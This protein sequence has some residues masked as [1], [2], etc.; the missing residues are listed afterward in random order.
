MRE[1]QHLHR[2]R[3]TITMQPQQQTVV[4]SAGP[5]V[6]PVYV[7]SQPYQTASVINSYLHRQSTVIGVLLIVGG[8]LSIDFNLVDVAV[9]ESWIRHDD[10]DVSRRRSFYS[11]TSYSYSSD[12][13]V[14]SNGV[15]CHGIWCGIMVSMLGGAWSKR[16]QTKT[17]KVK[18][19]TPKRR[20]SQTATG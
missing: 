5:V 17:A 10:D 4:T 2:N 15:I 14:R 9:G 18:T 19:A 1:G 6:Q 16:R 3:R 12:L 11:F 7:I 8:C 13:S 20:Q